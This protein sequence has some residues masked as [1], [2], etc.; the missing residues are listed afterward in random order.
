M[1]RADA[2]DVE[3]LS[4]LADSGFVDLAA[5]VADVG[6]DL[7]VAAAGD[8]FAAADG[9]CWL[10]VGVTFVVVFAA[11]FWVVPALFGLAE[12]SGFFAVS[13]LLGL[14][15]AGLAW[16]AGEVGA[17]GCGLGAAGGVGANGSKASMSSVDV[18][19]GAAAVVTGA[20]GDGLL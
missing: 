10:A 6:V 11:D 14:A 20:A 3:D 17:A 16:T 13:S 12:S 18:F 2:V 1:V 7:D 9:C 15:V 4:A 8:F 19:D 5:V